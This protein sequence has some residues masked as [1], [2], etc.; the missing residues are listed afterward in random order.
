MFLG[1]YISCSGLL[2][3]FVSEM[4][5]GSHLI[6]EALCSSLKYNILAIFHDKIMKQKPFERPVIRVHISV[7]SGV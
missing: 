5:Y 2:K 1:Y 4:C 7:F 3:V 6:L